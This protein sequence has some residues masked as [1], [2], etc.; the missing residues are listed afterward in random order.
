MGKSKKLLKETALAFTAAMQEKFPGV[1][2][3]IFLEQRDGFDA[4]VRVRIPSEMR[5]LHSQVLSESVELTDR[6]WDTG[7]WIMGLVVQEREPVHG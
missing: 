3:E 7:V 1:T 2:Q 4:W 6:F 5:A